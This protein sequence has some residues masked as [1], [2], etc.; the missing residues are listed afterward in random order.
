MDSPVEVYLETNITDSGLMFGNSVWRQAGIHSSNFGKLADYLH[1]ISEEVRL[2]WFT[3]LSSAKVMFLVARY[4]VLIHIGFS[5]MYHFRSGLSSEECTRSFIQVFISSSLIVLSAEAILYIRIH[6]FSGMNRKLMVYLVI[7]Y[8]I[9]HAFALAYG[10]KV[11]VSVKFRPASMPN[12]PCIPMAVDQSSLGIAYGFSLAS[13]VAIMSIMV[14]VAHQK[15]RNL[16]SSLFLL[17]YREGVL[18]FLCLSAL[19]CSNII[20]TYLAPLSYKFIMLEPQVLV[21]S[22]LSTRMLLHLRGWA[23]RDLTAEMMQPSFCAIELLAIVS[24]S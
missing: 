4:C 7:Q 23:E 15:Y 17:F 14:Y 8:I 18:Y 20:A 16:K 5:G 24:R 3:P 12:S 1:T 13:I 2:I 11:L 22:L 6:A 19:A 10:V 21:H 9:F